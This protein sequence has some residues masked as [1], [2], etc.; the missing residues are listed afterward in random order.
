MRRKNNIQH[1]RS[2]SNPELFFDVFGESKECL[3]MKIYFESYFKNIEISN[4]QIL[5]KAESLTNEMNRM[6]DRFNNFLKN[7]SN[8]LKGSELFKFLDEINMS[9]KNVGIEMASVCHA[10][11][12]VKGACSSLV[13]N[14]NKLLDRV[15]HE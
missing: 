5:E 2:I 13:A 15:E 14:F 9:S 7:I 12:S 4:I 8:I 10:A 11:E 3:H 1:A 6:E